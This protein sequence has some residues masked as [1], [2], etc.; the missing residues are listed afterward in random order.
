MEYWGISDSQFTVEDVNDLENEIGSLERELEDVEP[1][2]WQQF[3]DEF[4]DGSATGLLDT[5]A[6]RSDLG[7]VT[8]PLVHAPEDW[9]AS[10]GFGTTWVSSEIDQP[11]V[12]VEKDEPVIISLWDPDENRL[13]PTRGPVRNS[14]HGE[15]VSGEVTIEQIGPSGTFDTKTLETEVIFKEN[16]LTG[17]IEHHAVR[18]QL[19][20][21]VY[22]AYP[23]DNRA[24]AY[25]FMVGNSEEVFDSYRQDVEQTIA[26]LQE[27]SD[28]LSSEIDLR[29]NAD[30]QHLVNEGVAVR[31]KTTTNATGHYTIEADSSVRTYNVQAYRADDG[32]LQMLESQSDTTNPSFADVTID[33]LRQ[34]RLDGYNGTY[35][36]PMETN[37]VDTTQENPDADV[38]VHRVDGLPLEDME[39]YEKRLQELF[40]Q[41]L[42]QSS[43]EL[44]NQWEEMLTEMNEERLEQIHEEYQ[45]IIEDNEDLRDAIE[46]A[47]GRDLS[48]PDENLTNEELR[49]E[50]E[51]IREELN[52]Q[53]EI[54][55][56]GGNGE[57]E[58]GELF[59]E[60]PV[61]SWADED[62]VVLLVR[63]ADGERVPIGEEYISMESTGIGSQAVVVDGYPVAEDFSAGDL[64]IELAGSE[65][66][67]SGSTPIQNPA[68]D[69]TLP[70]IESVQW[71]TL[72][73][74]PDERIS[75]GVNPAPDSEY[76]GIQ[77]VEVFGP[78]GNQ[79]ESEI[80]GNRARFKTAGKGTHLVRFTL[81]S[82]T[83]DTFVVAERV[84][85]G[86]NPHSDPATIRIGDSPM[87]K[88]A[89]V[90]EHLSSAR[91]DDSDG[92][93]IDAFVEDSDSTPAEIHLRLDNALEGD[94]HNVDL[95]VV[96]EGDERQIGK[97]VQVYWHLN[98]LPEGTLFTGNGPITWDGDTRYGEVT[99]RDGKA[100]LVTHTDD[101][102]QLSL[103]ANTDPNLLDRAFHRMSR[104]THGISIPFLGFLGSLVD[105]GVTIAAEVVQTSATTTTAPTVGLEPT[106]TQGVTA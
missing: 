71:S 66:V 91:I 84:R 80:D 101:S 105:S 85:A 23:E 6:Y 18:T 39:E 73:P 43:T 14:F 12:Q 49:E 51:A 70:T 33:D 30:F 72:S 45:R 75:A 20:P 16:R 69:G 40:E 3:R 19:P 25:T 103:E 90:G 50:L 99:E 82:T 98:N 95:S 81:E 102:G 28:V 9:S 42:N 60:I 52:N 65:G 76:A 36:L 48:D 104:Y 44:M 62:D 88:H 32:I 55:L 86:Q 24:A 13:R 15:P 74:G 63:N 78:E 64:E 2:E 93:Q 94:T 89:V 96:T 8:Y 106:A 58:D 22:Q 1:S 87:G 34:Y 47:L 67:G 35:Y 4:Q 56:G 79:L 77:S 59:A 53:N 11:R 31:Q 10:G 100:I 29:E 83:G 46:E 54:N 38:T 37:R 57:I 5:D 68:F 7:D 92:L 26:N 61:P 21:G 17:D 97:H 41:Y 27:R